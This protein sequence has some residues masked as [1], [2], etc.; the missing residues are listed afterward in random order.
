MDVAYAFPQAGN[1]MNI[2]TRARS[3]GLLIA[4]LAT[5]SAAIPESTRAQEATQDVQAVGDSAAALSGE[6]LSALTGEPMVGAHVFLRVARR[7][8]VTDSSGKFRVESLPAG[9]DTIAIW[10]AAVE[11]QFRELELEPDRLTSAVFLISERIFEVA[12][13][14][15][16]VRAFSARRQRLERRKKFG[17]GV[18]ITREM[19]EEA[20][21]VLMTDMLRGIPRIDVES[22]RFASEP[23]EVRIG[24]GATAC[25]PM[26]FLDGTEAKYFTLD[27]VR[28]IEVEE[29]EIYRGASEIPP[30]FRK[31]GNTC[32]VIVVWT[33][34]NF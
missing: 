7:G 22:Y 19:I 29:L 9:R 17:N 33:R 10:Y 12:D 26:Y 27:E 6:V 15:V 4:L 2:R 25:I 8:A 20:K 28:P 34:G 30:E 32:G 31:M 16:E 1:H 5:L 24:Y 14:K 21:P 13:L 11:P 18:Y 23:V 3:T